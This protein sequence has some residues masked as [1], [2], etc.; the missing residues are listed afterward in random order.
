MFMHLV[1]I[2]PAE[3]VATDTRTTHIS[4]R[5]QRTVTRTTTNFIRNDWRRATI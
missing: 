4:Q 1:A 3:H 5:T 2:E